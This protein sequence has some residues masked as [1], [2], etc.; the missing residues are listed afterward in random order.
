[1]E[2]GLPDGMCIDSED[3]LWVALWGGSGVARFDPLTER[4][5]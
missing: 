5:Y 3:K 1:M 4:C 2:S